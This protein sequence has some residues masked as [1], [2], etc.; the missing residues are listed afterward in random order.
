MKLS[1]TTT[2]TWAVSLCAL[3]FAC[4]VL[5]QSAA[6]QKAFRD[7]TDAM[8]AGRLDDAAKDF[9]EV[10]KI[11]PQFA[12]GH[13]NLGLVRIQ[14]G[15]FEEAIS[16]LQRS[17]AL[18]PARAG[19]TCSSASLFTGKIITTRRLRHCSGRKKRIRAMRKCSCGWV[20]PSWAKG[21]L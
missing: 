15:Q 17:L 19:Q 11:E 4:P 10:T 2:R 12:E 8:R 7:G 16:S 14:Q 9:G 13:F 1:A 3:F 21:M 18:K 5:S 6:F 20:S